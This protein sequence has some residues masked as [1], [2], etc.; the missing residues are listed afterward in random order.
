MSFQRVNYCSK[1]SHGRR[2]ETGKHLDL[3]TALHQS[4]TDRCGGS[5]QEY[6]LIRWQ[7]PCPIPCPH[8]HTHTHTYTHTPWGVIADHHAWQSDHRVSLLDWQVLNPNTR[9]HMHTHT[10]TE[11]LG[12]GAIIEGEV[13]ASLHRNNCGHFSELSACESDRLKENQDNCTAAVFP[14]CVFSLKKTWN[15]QL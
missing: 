4:H 5:P 9:T 10:H 2:S 6:P 15:F 3:Y 14:R 1:W 7:Q 13:S 11:D 8:T 12:P